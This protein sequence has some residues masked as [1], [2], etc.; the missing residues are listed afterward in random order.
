MAVHA[1]VFSDESV[2]DQLNGSTSNIVISARLALIV[3]FS[4]RDENTASVRR[5]ERRFAFTGQPSPRHVQPLLDARRFAF[6][7]HRDFPM[8]RWCNSR[9]NG[10]LGIHGCQLW[11]KPTCSDDSLPSGFR[12]YLR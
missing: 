8:G 7:E 11:L 5:K 10:A 9:Q 2:G 3:I 6:A 4:S 1:W 12:R